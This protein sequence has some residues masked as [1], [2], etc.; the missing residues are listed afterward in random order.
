MIAPNCKTCGGG[1]ECRQ[2]RDC[3]E[4]N[5][6]TPSDIRFVRALALYAF[7]FWCAIVGAAFCCWPR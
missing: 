4:R 6:P 5:R 3:P 7:V 1:A 2:G